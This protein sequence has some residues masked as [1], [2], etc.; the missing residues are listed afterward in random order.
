MHTSHHPTHNP[1][2]VVRAALEPTLSQFNGWRSDLASFAVRADRQAGDRDRRKMLER[3]GA[4]EAEL[5]AARTDIILELA[6]APPPIAGHSRVADV[7]K[8]LDNIEASLRDLQGRL[9]H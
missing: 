2:A 8:A 1:N 9:S 6:E 7:E 3:L 4:I 5:R